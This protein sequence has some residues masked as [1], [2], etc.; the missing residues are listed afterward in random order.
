MFDEIQYFTRKNDVISQLGRIALFL[1]SSKNTNEFWEKFKLYPSP[2]FPAEPIA[3]KLIGRLLLSASREIRYNHQTQK[4]RSKDS[5]NRELL[6]NV[7]RESHYWVER[8]TANELLLSNS[9]FN[10]NNLLKIRGIQHSS[11]GFIDLSGIRRSILDL[12]GS[13]KKLFGFEKYDKLEMSQIE[14]N[15]AQK[16][17]ALSEACLNQ[18]KILQDFGYPIEIRRQVIHEYLHSS[19]VLKNLAKSGKIKNINQIED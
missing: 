14:L 13:L 17:K 10:S 7:L 3:Y 18:L 4:Y 15:E 9:N 19:G 8:L 12:A 11:P 5:E 6:E 2:N 1:A 16:Q